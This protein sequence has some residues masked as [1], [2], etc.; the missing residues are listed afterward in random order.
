MNEPASRR[1]LTLIPARGGSK[2]IPRK[3]VRPF[4]GTPA[5]ERVIRTVLASGLDAPY[6]STDDPEIAAIAR[7]AGAVVSFTRPPEFATDTAGTL[8][9]VRHALAWFDE[10]GLSADDLLVVYPTA[11]LLTPDRLRSSLAAFRATEASFLVPVL[12]SPQ[13]I[14]RALRV[15]GE[16]RIRPVQQ[17]ALVSRTQDLEPA[18]F[19]A[20]QFYF[21]RAKSWREE[22][23]LA[24]VDSAAVVLS[25]TEVVDIDTEDDWRL[26]EQLA[27]LL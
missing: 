17:E 25:S 8:S 4:L 3:N 5:I 14:E 23:P 21:G 27:R 1:L 16:G 19:D 7:S 6:V 15:T 26:A 9:V 18:Y 11:V 12:A 22:G 2:R 20:G 13:P 24:A 10:Q